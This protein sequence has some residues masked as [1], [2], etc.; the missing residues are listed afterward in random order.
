[1]HLRYRLGLTIFAVSALVA[2]GLIGFSEWQR[3]VTLDA[4]LKQGLQ[5]LQDAFK[6]SLS[7]EA[8]RALSLARTVAADNTVVIAMRAGDRQALI[9][10]YVPRFPDL[11]KALGIQQFQFHTP[12]ATS[13]LRVHR[14][15]KFGDDLS[16]FRHTVVA[17]NQKKA[18]VSGLESGIEGLG[19]RGV[20]PIQD[21]KGHIGSV[22]FGLSLQNDFFEKIGAKL[23]VPLAF[24]L[25]KDGKL[26]RYAGH[27]DKILTLDDKTLRDGLAGAVSVPQFNAANGRY[28]ATLAPVRDFNGDAIGVVVIARNVAD[29]EAQAA[30]RLWLLVAIALASIALIGFAVVWLDRSVA[31]PLTAIIATL[32]RLAQGDTHIGD[33]YQGRRDEIGELAKAVTV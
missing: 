2:A 31:R 29:F 25:V 19:I 9:D 16:S 23:G 10:R 33:S 7:T 21:A 32:R 27:D 4:A 24:H 12:P 18:A 30:Q 28:G 15:D 3:R 11:R 22:E 20:A 13:Y 14:A 5:Q 1:M 8:E 26:E 6:E 17:T